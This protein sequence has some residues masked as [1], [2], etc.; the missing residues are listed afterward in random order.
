MDPNV[1]KIFGDKIEVHVIPRPQEDEEEKVK[2]WFREKGQLKIDNILFVYFLNQLDFRLYRLGKDYIFTRVINNVVEET[3]TVGMKEVIMNYLAD[4]MEFCDDVKALELL[5]LIAKQ[6]P[7]IFARGNLEY[8]EKLN[9]EFKKDTRAESFIYFRNCFVCVTAEGHSVHK[10]EELDKPIW[11]NQ[12]LDREF[13]ETEGECDFKSFVFKI[14]GND[15]G[16]YDSFRSVI[17]YLLHTYK[18]PSIAKAIIFMDEKLD[19][20]SNGGCGKSLLGNAISKIRKSLRLGGKNFF[21]ERFAF[22]SYE[23]GT[24][25]IEFNDL[26]R[27]FRFENLFTA[28]TDNIMIEKKNKDEMIIPFEQS[29]KILLST[30]YTIKGVDESSLRRQFVLEFSDYFSIR[31]S[32]EDE[33]GHRFFDDWCNYE[34]C[35]FYL[36]MIGCLRFYL[37][38][39]LVDYEKKNLE[40]KK[41]I[42]STSE[43]FLEFAEDL[44]KDTWYDK[45]ETY[46]KFIEEY[47]D[48]NNSK[49]E[50]KKF[51]NWVKIFARIKNLKYF[52]KRTASQERLFILRN[53]LDMQ[54][55]GE[56]T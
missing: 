44:L 38:K 5:K 56:L 22:Q 15:A 12:M 30:N 37:E 28:I 55:E 36:F 33:Y 43:E 18:D 2:F 4:H 48:F 23:P 25:I 21:F 51:T 16:R 10:Y 39:G 52:Q 6:T 42:E 40:V 17:G 47:P 9:D 26:S 53:D 14:S 35:R 7:E 27:N 34:W 13:Y 29:P 41:L 24:S 19:D 3:D 8:L 54:N 31:Y 20:G 50:Q 11:K 1:R 49:M 45:R 46:R 32:P